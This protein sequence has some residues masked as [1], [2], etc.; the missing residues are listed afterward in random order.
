MGGRADDAGPHVQFV[1]GV[2]NAMPA[3]EH[4]LDLMLGE[5]RRVLP[6]ATCAAGI[7]ANQ[8]RV[9]EWAMVRGA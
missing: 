4:L 5:L 1:T 9:M 3:E 2:K 8:G 7:G 6:K